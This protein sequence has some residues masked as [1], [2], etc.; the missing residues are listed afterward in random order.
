MTH[1]FS[2]QAGKPVKITIVDEKEVKYD[3]RTGEITVEYEDGIET[4][5]VENRGVEIPRYGDPLELDGESYSTWEELKG[6]LE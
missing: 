5:D 3:S 6:E 1:G 2:S 4:Y